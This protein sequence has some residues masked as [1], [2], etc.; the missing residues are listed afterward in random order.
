[1]FVISHVCAIFCR[2]EKFK[3]S[4]QS[5]FNHI[6]SYGD[7]HNGYNIQSNLSSTNLK[8][9]V[10]AEYNLPLKYCISIVITKKI[11]PPLPVA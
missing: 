8:G 4:I 11:V 7:K 10:K 3:I 5:Q 2:S 9:A 6:S 1:M